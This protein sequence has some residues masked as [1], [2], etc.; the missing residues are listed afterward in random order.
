MSE[1]ILDH[2]IVSSRFFFPRI[3]DLENTYWVDCG[4]VRLAC[5]YQPKHP[6]AKTIVFFHGNGEIA[7]DYIDFL[8]PLFD[9]L[10]C[11]CF[12]AEYRGYGMSGGTPGM[13]RMLSDVAPII[14]SLHRPPGDLVLFGRSIGSLYAVHGASLFPGIAGLIIE[15]GIA[16]V[17]ERVLLRVR[18]EE[19]GV[20]LEVMEKEVDKYFNMQE[21]L[22][23]YKGPMLVMHALHDTLVDYSHGRKLC[24]WGAQPPH[25][26]T[27]K[28]FENGD[29]NDIFA[30]NSKE[31]IRQ[32]IIF[33]ERK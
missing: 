18:P 26:K 17:L 9:Q 7:A 14:E 24:E 12:V 30:V 2:P 20:T 8:V 19:L 21:K 16:D 15:S 28:V 4:D 23:K 31:Y 13:A 25:L 10:G 11:D 3:Q 6:G 22:K 5:Y 29:H 27:L 33:L 1:S 32:L